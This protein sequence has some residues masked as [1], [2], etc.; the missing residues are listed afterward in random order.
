MPVVNNLGGVAINLTQTMQNIFVS[1]SRVPNISVGG[2]KHV[3][4]KLL[5]K[6]IN[7]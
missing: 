3:G 1:Y 6:I 7:V 5:K 2:N 4:R